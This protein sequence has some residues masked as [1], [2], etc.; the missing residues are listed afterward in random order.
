MKRVAIY[1]RM[2]L[3]K[4]SSESTS[5]QI[6]RCRDFADQR[7]SQ[8]VEELIFT[9]KAVS[10]GTRHN[11]PGLLEVIDRISEWDVLLCYD[12]T[13]LARNSEDL[14]WIRNKLRV[15]RRTAYAVDTGLDIFNV[16]A[17]VMGV[18]GEE[19]L[20]KLRHDTRRGL[21]GQFERGFWTGGTVYGYTSEPD[22]SSGKKNNRGEPVPDGYRL[23]IDEDQAAV[24]RRI[25]VDYI[26]G[27]S[28]KA[29]SKALNREHVAPPKKRQHRGGSWAP[30][31]IR[32]MLLNSLYKGEPIWGKTETFKDHET[33]IRK[34]YRRPES[35]WIR[36]SD[37][38]L[39]I[40]DSSVWE[41]A[42]AVRKLRSRS[43][44][45]NS[46][47][48]IVGNKQGGRKRGKNLLA[49]WL[50]CDDCG[51]AFNVLYRNKWGCGHRYN[52]GIETCQ[53][54]VRISQV[55]LEARV[56]GGLEARFLPPENVEY[57]VQQ[58]ERIVREERSN[59]RT[60]RD[61]QRLFQL[62]GEI[63][64]LIG[65]AATL[66]SN[67]RV[68][69]EIGDRERE[70]TEIKSLLARRKAPLGSEALTDSIRRT[71]SDLGNMFRSSPED[72]KKALG[73]LLGENRLRVKKEPEE[74]FSVFGEGVLCFGGT[75]DRTR[76]CTSSRTVAP[77]ATASTNSATPAN[78]Q[79]SS[80]KGG[81]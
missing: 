28:D 67:D 65:L 20:E 32:A 66:G 73:A 60:R 39:V 7:G 68:A 1:A 52:R 36:R 9:D 63:D 46:A 22:Y 5:D 69:L 50:Q 14:G 53:N 48:Q 41:Q 37:E 24:I 15:S 11:R 57:V 18:L 42:Q 30:T 80:R 75:G 45:R 54:S 8:V 10:G 72:A 74:G 31:A 33:G 81:W 29:I 44:Q 49:G 47:G 56:L 71:L 35:E 12:F 61:E 2:S 3:E 64:N 77:K 78:G 4:Q 51:S 79:S 38:A 34:R 27:Q 43:K 26:A 58:A 13:R 25:F 19:Y 21:Q 76:T 70:V 16:G 40:V 62:E 55:D 23:K 17:K 59:D 6:A